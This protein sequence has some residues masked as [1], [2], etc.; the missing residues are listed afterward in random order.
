MASSS[1]AVPP[2]DS[3][4]SLGLREFMIKLEVKF[5]KYASSCS[6]WF[7]GLKERYIKGD[8]ACLTF[9]FIR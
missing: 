2:K 5:M 1:T 6:L 7:I 3:C 9:L 4:S 8:M